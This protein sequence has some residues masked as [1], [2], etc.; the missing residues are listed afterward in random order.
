MPLAGPVRGSID[1]L[2]Q[3]F[4]WLIVVIHRSDLQSLILIQSPSRNGDV[5]MDLGSVYQFLV[6]LNPIV[7]I[8]LGVVVFFAGKFAKFIGI[9]AILVGAVLLVLPYMLRLI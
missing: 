5:N 7:L 2:E 3:L 4:V 6:H 9:I 8:I 1:Q